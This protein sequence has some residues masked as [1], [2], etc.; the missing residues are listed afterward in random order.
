ML[1]MKT[2]CK[3]HIICLLTLFTSCK[4]T[5]NSVSGRW[6]SN[7]SDTLSINKNF[8][9]L[10]EKKQ[11]YHV[12]QNG[13]PLYDT[14]FIFLEGNWSISNKFLKLTFNNIGG[15][16]K[17]GGCRG[18]YKGNKWFSKFELY[19]FLTCKSPTHYFVVFS[20]IK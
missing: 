2:L 12:K 5:E 13:S 15:E 9:F 1:L 8:T 16:E 11:G 3:S 10:L 7:N 17:F 14:S 4:L 6:V 18:L 20:K 19:R